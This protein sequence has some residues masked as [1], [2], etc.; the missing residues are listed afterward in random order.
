MNLPF[1][2]MKWIQFTLFKMQIEYCAAAFS[3]PTFLYGSCSAHP[4]RIADTERL[5]SDAGVPWACYACPRHTSVMLASGTS[6]SHVSN[7]YLKHF[8]PCHDNFSSNQLNFS[9]S[10]LS[11]QVSERVLSLYSAMR[12]PF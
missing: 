5:D 4:C 8:S 9:P 3:A 2:K 6:L 7:F 11:F 1:T 10:F 12:T